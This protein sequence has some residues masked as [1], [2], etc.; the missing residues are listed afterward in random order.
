[1]TKVQ[2]VSF[3]RKFLIFCNFSFVTNIWINETWILSVRKICLAK[4][5]EVGLIYEFLMFAINLY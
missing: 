2:L 1:M 4:S 5:V 3:R